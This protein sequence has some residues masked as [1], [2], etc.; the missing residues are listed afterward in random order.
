MTQYLSVGKK[1]LAP[2]SSFWRGCCCCLLRKIYPSRSY[3]TG[4][5]L[6]DHKEWSISFLWRQN[7][8]SFL[9]PPFVGMS[10][11]WLLC[12]YQ[13]IL[14]Q[15]S[16]QSPGLLT[17]WQQA[18]TIKT[19]VQADNTQYEVWWPVIIL[20]SRRFPM[21]TDPEQVIPL[22]AHR[23]H[24][25]FAHAWHDI[26]RLIFCVCIAGIPEQSPICPKGEKAVAMLLL[27]KNG[28]LGTAD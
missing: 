5:K 9:V 23:L 15:G 13:T 27:C 19:L 24:F 28:D 18:F 22:V 2:Y 21:T 3:G 4:I 10:W 25:C 1:T 12:I 11:I 26:Q 17:Q 7:T 14:V 6:V 16:C 8:S 20:S